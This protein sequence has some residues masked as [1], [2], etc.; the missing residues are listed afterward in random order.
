VN[1][2]TF[3]PPTYY[4]IAARDFAIMLAA[5]TLNRLAT[6]FGATTVVQETRH[7]KAAA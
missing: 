6:A 2:L 1:L 3:D 4:D 5:L 7:L